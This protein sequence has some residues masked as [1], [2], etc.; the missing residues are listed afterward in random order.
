M[1]KTSSYALKYNILTHTMQ[2]V[3]NVMIIF[4][5]GRKNTT[6]QA[7]SLLNNLLFLL[8]S[9]E[10]HLT[11]VSKHVHVTQILVIPDEMENQ[12]GAIVE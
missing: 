2:I 12:L 5:H 7:T 6:N 9:H 1:L 11:V 10:D 8:P 3:I 4:L